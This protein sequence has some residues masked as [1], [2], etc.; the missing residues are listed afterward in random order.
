MNERECGRINPILEFGHHF[1]CSITFFSKIPSTWVTLSG[2]KLSR[3][4]FVGDPAFPFQNLL[5][6]KDRHPTSL[7]LHPN[8]LGRCESVHLRSLFGSGKERSEGGK[9]ANP[10]QQLIKE[11]QH[12][13]PFITRRPKNDPL[14]A[15]LFFSFRSTYP[16]A[17]ATD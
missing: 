5:P 8:L 6:L 14:S 7:G 3:I 4:A 2:S 9:T 1:V 17:K 10:I 15:Q 16:A 11:K 13:L 12:L